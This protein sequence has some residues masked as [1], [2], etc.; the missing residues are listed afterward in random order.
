VKLKKCYGCVKLKFCPIR[1]TEIIDTK[2]VAS[3]ELC[4]ECSQN[5]ISTEAVVKKKQHILDLADVKTP[6]QLLDFIYQSQTNSREETCVCGLTEAEFNKTGRFGCAKCYERFID[7]FEEQIIPYHQGARRHVGKRPKKVTVGILNNDPN[8]RRK[9]LKLHYA[10]ALELEQYE[11]LA[12]IKKELD[13]LP[14]DVP[15]LPQTSEDQ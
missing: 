2:E 13:A 3:Y 12:L 14:I 8:E 4:L 5:G 10:K 6:E 9:V 1:I 15:T 7:Y 11:Q